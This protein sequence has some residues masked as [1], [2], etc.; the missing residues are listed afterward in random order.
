MI[1]E[2]SIRQAFHGRAALA[3]DPATAVTGVRAKIRSRRRRRRG[4]AAAAAVA[5]AAAVIPG[6]ELAQQQKTGPA[7][8]PWPAGPLLE[9]VRIPMKPSWLPKGMRETGRVV[10]VGRTAEERSY[11]AEGMTR[12]LA[13]ISIER[14]RAG[15]GAEGTGKLGLAGATPMYGIED[16]PGKEVATSTKISGLP[17]QV[18]DQ[19]V[20]CKVTWTAADGS[21]MFVRAE[22]VWEVI[23]DP[24]AVAKRVAGSLVPDPE[25]TLTPGLAANWLPSAWWMEMAGVGTGPFSLD[26]THGCNSWLVLG[27]LRGEEVTIALDRGDVVRQ[28]PPRTIRG[29]NAYMVET[30]D[31]LGDLRVD[32]GGGRRMTITHPSV[33]SDHAAPGRSL[34]SADLVKIAENVAVGPQT[35]CSWG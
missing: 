10:A 11:S 6:L 26:F 16:Q 20:T 12:S 24:C 4:V 5:V 22:K 31:F 15:V 23:S 18:Y 3:A 14:E 13:G 17:A 32:L 1:T 27:N 30:P 29:R 19:K 34:S 35:D 21:A 25:T 7:A 33:T 28:V 9:P 8:Q 2:E